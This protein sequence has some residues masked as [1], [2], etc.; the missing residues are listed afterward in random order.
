MNLIELPD[1]PAAR[2]ECLI[3]PVLRPNH[4]P[5]TRRPTAGIDLH[6]EWQAVAS[7]LAGWMRNLYELEDEAVLA[8]TRELVEAAQDVA[9]ALAG[10]GVDPPNTLVTNGDGG[11]VMR[12]RL[13]GRTWSI[14]LDTDGSIESSLMAGS[15]LLWRHSIHQATAPES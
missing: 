3:R 14:E 5:E 10:Y 2:I 13:P 12:W 6:S 15:R 4:I 1:T 7:H 9:E 8:P 11:I